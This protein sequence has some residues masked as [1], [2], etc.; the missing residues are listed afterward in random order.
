MPIHKTEPTINH[1]LYADD[2]LFMSKAFVKNAHCIRKFL[3]MLELYTGLSIKRK[4]I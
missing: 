2:I 4:K 3:H 1:L